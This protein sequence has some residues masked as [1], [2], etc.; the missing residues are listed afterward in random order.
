MKMESVSIMKFCKYKKKKFQ[1][2]EIQSISFSYTTNKKIKIKLSDLY[3]CVWFVY[4]TKTCIYQHRIVTL[5]QSD[6]KNFR[7][8][9]L[10][11]NYY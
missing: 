5:L 8:N 10:Y 6:N 7:I 4:M 9:Y 3:G 11:S 1:L 2:K